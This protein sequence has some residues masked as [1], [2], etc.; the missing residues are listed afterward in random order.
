MSL[1]WDRGLQQSSGNKAW[2]WTGSLS[3]T[4]QA[5]GGKIGVRLRNLGLHG[6][7]KAELESQQSSWGQCE[8]SLL[9]R[10]HR[11]EHTAFP[12]TSQGWAAWAE[13]LL[14]TH[15]PSPP[16]LALCTGWSGHLLHLGLQVV[17]LP[18]DG[19][20]TLSPWLQRREFGFFFF[21]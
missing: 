7:V 6:A 2:K 5:V 14:P 10:S 20:W 11:R 1:I 21:L 19:P 18:C 16:P 4:S 15:T 17:C 9:V 12:S 13:L 3:L 8:C